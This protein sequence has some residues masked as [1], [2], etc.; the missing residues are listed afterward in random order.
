MKAL[1][2]DAR[3]VAE[4]NAGGCR[5]G[6]TV[7]REANGLALGL[8]LGHFEQGTL[9]VLEACSAR[10]F[11]RRRRY[12]VDLDGALGFVPIY[13]ELARRCTN[14]AGLPS[15]A[16]R[17]WLNL[18]QFLG[19]GACLGEPDPFRDLLVPLPGCEVGPVA[20]EKTRRPEAAGFCR[21]HTLRSGWDYRP[22][23]H[24]PCWSWLGGL[25]WSASAMR[26]ARGLVP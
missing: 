21:V 12:A 13:A 4:P 10:R 5:A 22:K 2:G 9:V 14:P 18:S 25:S 11:L 20:H 19:T 15:A 16:F 7:V 8:G 17:N 24:Y 26:D 23:S 1:Q 6:I 3:T